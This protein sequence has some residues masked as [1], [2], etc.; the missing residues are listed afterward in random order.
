MRYQGEEILFG[1]IVILI[2]DISFAP[3]TQ[4]LRPRGAKTIYEK[5]RREQS[6][7][8]LTGLCYSMCENYLPFKYERCEKD[9]VV[10]ICHTQ[11]Y[12]KYLNVSGDSHHAKRNKLSITYKYGWNI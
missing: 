10:R 6:G 4:L 8:V 5:A 9:N 3:K 11:K 1:I 7:N 12:I 2:T